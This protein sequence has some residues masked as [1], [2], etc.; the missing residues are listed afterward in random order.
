MHDQEIEKLDVKLGRDSFVRD[1]LRH[2]TGTLEEIVGLEE[3]SGFISVVGQR[4]GDDINSM[5]RTALNV[6]R[7]DR[8]QVARVLVD[9]KQRI[10][11]N[12]SIVSEDDEKIV[13][14][15]TSCPFGNKVIGRPS[16]CMTT[17][18]VFGTIAAENLGYAKVSLDETIASGAPGCLITIYLKE[19]SESE[20]TDGKEYF[21][22]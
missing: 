11:G 13:L 5:Y 19:S 18:T 16:L 12:F 9:L 20:A 4:L 22:V 3:A 17:S 10:K 2:L 14:Q 6:D 15:T 7:L 8:S 21:R 1:L